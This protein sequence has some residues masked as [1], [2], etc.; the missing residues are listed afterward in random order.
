MPGVIGGDYYVIVRSDIYNQIPESSEVNNLTVSLDTTHID[1]ELLAFDTPDTASLVTGEAVYYR[2]DVAEGETLQL[3]FDRAATEGHTELFVSYGEMP[4]RSNFDYR[5][6]QAD[7]PDQ[8]LVIDNT[9]EGSYYVMGYNASGSTGDYTMTAKTLQ[10]SI[11]ELGTTAGSNK[12][13]VTV[14]IEGAEFTTQTSAMLIGADGVEHS[15]NHIYWK[16]SLELWATFDLRGLATGYYDV[17]LQDDTN[18]ALLDDGFTVNNAEQGHIEYSITSP[19]TL[20]PNEI[21]T[22]SVYYQNVGATDVAAPLLTISGDAF[23]KQI[24]DNEFG[25]T[26]VE[27]LG[28]SSEGPAGILSPGASNNFKLNFK[29]LLTGAH[30]QNFIGISTFDANYVIDWNTLLESSK[31]EHISQEAWVTVKANLIAELGTTVNDYQNALAQNATVLAMLEDR[32]NDVNRLFAMEYNQATNN[33]A[34]Y[35]SDEIGVFGR[36]HTFRW[37]ITATSQANGDVIVS[38][39]GSQQTFTHLVDGSY[40]GTDGATLTKNGEGFTCQQQDGKQISFNLDGTFDTILEANGIREQAIYVNHQLSQVTFSNGESQ[41]FTYNDHGRLTQITDQNGVATTFTYDQNGEYQTSVTSA[42][43]TTLYEYVTE[44]GPAQHQLSAITLPDGTVKHFNYD[45]QGRLYTESLNE[46]PATATYHYLGANEVEVT[47]VNGTT[48]HLWYNDRGQ[49]AQVEDAA[50]NVNELRYDSTGNFIENV[51]T[52]GFLDSNPLTVPEILSDGVAPFDFSRSREPQL[53]T[54]NPTIVAVDNPETIGNSITLSAVSSSTTQAAPI[55]ITALSPPKKLDIVIAELTQKLPN[56]SSVRWPTNELS[57]TF[58]TSVPSYYSQIFGSTDSDANIQMTSCSMFTLEQKHAAEKALTLWASVAHLSF[59]PEVNAIGQITFANNIVPPT[60]TPEGMD[61]YTLGATWPLSSG[62]GEVEGDIWINSSLSDNLNPT[63]GSKAFKTLLHELGHAL[64][65]VHPNNDSSGESYVTTLMRSGESPWYPIKP[66]VYDIAAIQSLYGANLSYESGDNKYDNFTPVMQAI[67]DAGGIDTIDAS[68]ETKESCYIDLRP[69]GFSSIG[70]TQ[71]KPNVSIAYTYNLNGTEYGFIENANGGLR[72]DKIIGNEKD[73]VLDGGL[74]SDTLIGGLGNDTYILDYIGDKVIETSDIATE[75]DLVKSS[76]TYS[77]PA[78]VE[79]LILTGDN[80]I[81]GIGNELDNEITGNS[82]PNV[83]YGES[84]VDTYYAGAGDTIYDSDGKGKVYYDTDHLL[85]GGTREKGEKLFVSADGLVRY[86]ELSDGGTIIAITPDGIITVGVPSSPMKFGADGETIFSGLPG[87]EI[88][89]ITKNT[90][91]PAPPQPPPTPGPKIPGPRTPTENIAPNDPNDIVGPQGFGDEHWISSKN[92]LQ[93]TIHFE[94]LATATAPA[95]QVTITQTL[96]SD[97][98]L[99]SFRLGDFGWGDFYVTVPD[100]TSFYINRLDLRST[101]GYMVDVVAGVDVATHEAYWSFTTIDP[102]T[103]EIPEDPTIGFLPPDIDGM[104]GQA[105]ANYTIKANAD[106]STGTVIDAKATIIFTTQEPIDT[107]AISNTLD[108]QAPESHVEAVANATVESAQFLVRWSG[109]DVGSAIA[110]Y[111][112]YASDNGGAY[113]PWLENTTL[114]EATYAGQP[115]HSYAFYT[116]ASDNAGNK[117]AAPALADLTIQVAAS[118]A[119]T[120]TVLPDITV[121]ALSTDGIYAAG[122][123]LD[124][125]V[126]FSESLFVDI[127]ALPPVI[128]MTIGGRAIEAAYQSGNG[129]DTLIFRHIIADGENNTDGTALGSAML[130]NGATLRDVAGNPLVDLSLIP[131]EGGIPINNAPVVQTA[132]A[133]QSATEDQPFFFQF[134]SDAFTDVDAGDTLSYTATIS[135]GDPLPGWLSFDHSTRTFS[136]TPSNGDAGKVSVKVMATDS[137]N[138]TASDTFDLMVAN[139]NDLTGAVTFWKTG[140]AIADVTSMLASDTMT[141]GADGLYHHLDMP[142]GTY[143]L[144]SAKVSDTAESNAV[145]A[146]DALAALKIAVGM[147]PNAD[148]SAVSPYQYLAADVNKD[149]QVK[150]ADALN[151][152]KMAVKLSTAPEKE[153]LFVPESVGS[154]TMS[155]THVV[156]PDNPIP[157]TLN[158]DQEL[159]LI[160]IVKGD[161]NGSWVA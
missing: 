76:I 121:V 78:N 23:L 31:P 67:W 159:D 99:S 53:M 44:A 134:S 143:A 42:E 7:S 65:L 75:I 120:D 90:K 9:R 82:A 127:A 107:P 125:S 77:L 86:E 128:H 89:L 117:E 100:N 102:N 135:N 154:E 63:V 97:L 83:L 54:V 2:V 39:A 61:E 130:L 49:L 84:G 34:L 16:D 114:T 47:D 22:V 131:G 51:G 38:I 91:Q 27:F 18:K 70:T 96:D 137:H 136:G 105:F 79:N 12:G 60:K 20:R 40:K 161:V 43:G 1:V 145:K 36:D 156:W 133:D 71:D 132:L 119:L 98:N 4:S 41:S 123:S 148:G 158:A 101:K 141:T 94:N 108:T 24:G 110:G 147:N 37:D 66:M 14:R 10:F 104:V 28:I 80:I 6:N 8:N 64:G 142:D 72:N 26:S 46:G 21:G 103:G 144:T 155:R 73:N 13:Q 150:A 118:A 35:R 52:L 115:G 153:W 113:T 33:G 109:S 45:D 57:Y 11:T 106:A 3:N 55:Q 81:N 95:Q 62:K 85:T 160:G 139:I 25:G 112:V 111:T 116:V 146:N 129:T 124:F 151:I 126:R 74:N 140:E 50:R 48:T 138:A 93:Y 152:L 149:G 157:L 59:N 58:L 17:E 19:A 122:H 32:T 5:Y 68:N 29:P 69:G 30:E 56:G 87:M 15:A 88:I 92:P